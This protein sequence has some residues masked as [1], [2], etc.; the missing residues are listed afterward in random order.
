MNNVNEP[1]MTQS[2]SQ[3]S[4]QMTYRKP[5]LGDRFKRFVGVKPKNKYKIIRCNKHSYPYSGESNQVDNRKTSVFTFLPLLLFNEFKHFLNLYYLILCVT[6]FIK[7]LQVGKI[8]HF[9]I[10]FFGN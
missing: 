5:T 8:C 7:V 10:W 2:S 6:Q 1:L 9:Y 4:E 3:Y